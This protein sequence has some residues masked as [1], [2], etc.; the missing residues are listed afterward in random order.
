MAGEQRLIAASVNAGREITPGLST[1][2]FQRPV[3]QWSVPGTA[4]V[5]DVAPDGQRFLVASRVE[6]RETIPLTVTTNWATL[7]TKN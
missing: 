5:Y 2:L 4:Y 7:L 1:P 6:A 3:T